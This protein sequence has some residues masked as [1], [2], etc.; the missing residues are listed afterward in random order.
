MIWPFRRVSK[1]EI[2]TFDVDNTIGAGTRVTGD[3]RGPGGFRID[4]T[5]EGAIEADG[6]VVVG[7]GGTIEGSVRGRDVVVLGLVRGD[8]RAT[9]HIEVGPTGRIL[10]D[11]TMES[12]RVHKGGVF[13]G[14]S[15]M[16]GADDLAP[17]LSLPLRGEHGSA[18][19]DVRRGRTLP[20]PTGAVPPPA[21]PEAPSL[22]GVPVAPVSEERLVAPDDTAAVPGPVSV[23]RR[24]SA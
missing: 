9:G 5:I 13:R 20:P 10:G 15:R 17:P 6:P 22:A 7:E 23:A 18:P 1:N 19:G 3:L 11:V 12:I 4:G 16:G 2:P 24:A 21:L 8:V 14:T